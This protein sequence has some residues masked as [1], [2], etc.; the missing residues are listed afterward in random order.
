MTGNRR[1]TII[2]EIR[3]VKKDL[4]VRDSYKHPVTYT[5]V[6]ALNVVWIPLIW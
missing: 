5:H 6:T 2:K 4:T 1:G 3:N